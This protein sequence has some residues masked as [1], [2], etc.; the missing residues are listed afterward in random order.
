MSV[1]EEIFELK[2][3]YVKDYFKEPDYL[4]MD[5][6]SYNQLKFDLF[7]DDDEEPM[8]LDFITMGLFEFDGMS[9]AVTSNPEDRRLDVR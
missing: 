7:A 9:I 6:T 8:N 4:I 1:I 3:R 2:S 5:S